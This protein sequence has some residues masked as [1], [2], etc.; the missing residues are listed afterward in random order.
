MR[1][2]RLASAGQTDRSLPANAIITSQWFPHGSR[3]EE[4]WIIRTYDNSYPCNSYHGIFVL[5]F[6]LLI[7]EYNSQVDAIGHVANS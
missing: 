7:Q 1:I 4:P 5:S 6:I 2:R 3:P